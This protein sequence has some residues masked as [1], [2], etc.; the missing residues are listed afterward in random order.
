M[1]GSY[2]II[3]AIDFPKGSNYAMDKLFGSNPDFVGA[4]GFEV[5]LSTNRTEIESRN[6]M[7]AV[8]SY[9]KANRPLSDIRWCLRMHSV[10][11]KETEG[12][13]KNMKGFPPSFVR[14]DPHVDDL[15]QDVEK[16]KTHA[17]KVVGQVPFPIKISGGID[18]E[19]LRALSDLKNVKRFDVTFEQAEAIVR[20]LKLKAQ[21]AVPAQEKKQG[22]AVKKIGN[23]G[24][25][26]L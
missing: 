21:E 13:L 1:G 11:D 25:I 26:R 22:P 16:L 5:L 17:E 4:D 3:C 6:E 19:K 2:R 14:V 10:D 15:G 12:I 20:S 7:R 24:R 9:L 23:V 8:H 18:L